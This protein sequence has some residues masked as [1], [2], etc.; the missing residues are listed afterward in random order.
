MGLTHIFNKKV[1]SGAFS[2]S[3]L[4]DAETAKKLPLEVIFHLILTVDYDLL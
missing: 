3:P 2:N 1:D 4:K